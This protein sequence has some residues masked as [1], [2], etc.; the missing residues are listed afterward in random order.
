MEGD[1]WRS[2][3]ITLSV[4]GHREEATGVAAVGQQSSGRVALPPMRG[5]PALMLQS[6]ALLQ[7]LPISRKGLDSQT[8]Q[9][10][11]GGKDK[12]VNRKPLE[13]IQVFSPNVCSFLSRGYHTQ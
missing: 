11:Y 1:L 6:R 2:V 5:G 9:L 12:H 3:A 10:E 13:T 8:H 7:Q 4:S